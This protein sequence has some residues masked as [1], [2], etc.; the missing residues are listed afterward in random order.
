MLPCIS[1]RLHMT[2]MFRHFNAIMESILVLPTGLGNSHIR[3][4]GARLMVT[5]QLILLHAFLST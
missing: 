5:M 4:V 1:R 2:M 3:F